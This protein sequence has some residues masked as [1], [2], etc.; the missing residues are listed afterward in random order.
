MT[1]S[2]TVAI[3]Q[4]VTWVY[5]PDLA[6]TTQFYSSVLQLE[7]VLDQGS[8]HIYRA[9]PN[10]FIGVC[11]ERP[12]REVEPRGV[13]ITLVTDRVDAWYERLRA[14]QIPLDGPPQ[15]SQAFNV[16]AFFARDPNGYR[17]EFQS[18]LDPT[19]PEPTQ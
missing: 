6:Q 18:F 10:A 8:C 2:T 3:A 14:L 5:T 17:I 16:Y 13:V 7:R 4:Q 15:R 1:E 12:G 9:A 19:W 11:Q